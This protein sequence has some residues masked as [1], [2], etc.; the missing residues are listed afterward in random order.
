MTVSGLEINDSKVVLLALKKA[1]SLL[2][3][4]GFVQKDLAPG[5]IEDGIIKNKEELIKILKLL[6]KQARPRA[7]NSSY[8]IVSISESLV[9][10]TT[11]VLPK[12]EEEN[13]RET[14]EINL[15]EFLPG[16][17]ED[18]F[19]GFQEIE[20]VENGTE[21]LVSSAKKQTIETYLEVLNAANFIPV[22]LEPSS[23]SVSRAFSKPQTALIL[24][25]EKTYAQATILDKGLVRFATAFR[26]S[27]AEKFFR[28][29]KR[30]LDYYR[31][32]KKTTNLPVILC[33]EHVT[34]D[35]AKQYGDYLKVEIKLA[36]KNMILEDQKLQEPII[37]GAALRGLTDQKDDKSLS[38][39]PLGSQEAYEEKRALRF[40]GGITNLAGITCILFLIIFFGFWGLLIY[41]NRSYDSQL[42]N[43]S[44]TKVDPQV[45]QIQKK[46]QEINPKLTY[47]KE[48]I[49]GQTFVSPIFSE[50]KESAGAG[51]S[52][53][54][55][56]QAKDGK[57]IT[58]S[59]VSKER[60]A[61]AA[62]KDGLTNSK[63][64]DKVDISETNAA[65]NQISFTITLTKKA[66]KK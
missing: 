52:L 7:I 58:V 46:I 65:D 48:L 47:M 33:G 27:D 51:I 63:L 19:W 4:S 29:I 10:L 5:T 26:V 16:K 21:V 9:Y 66:G 2:R 8:V 22:A 24:T 6:K 37:L 28:N 41:F 11:K 1:G 50:I 38:L 60:D 56:S 59:G 61:L 55:I 25:V 57:T 64:F 30:V 36:K 49:A 44:K 12:I 20:K 43:L 3:V 14:I 32:E 53:T 17:Q 34:E 45:S 35:L 62:F 13:L 39:L 23:L 15:R 31:A 54:N 42:S 40:L 18:I